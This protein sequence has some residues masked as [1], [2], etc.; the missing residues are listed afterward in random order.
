MG[1]RRSYCKG[2]QRVRRATSCELAA[3]LEDCTSA[4][5]VVFE[6]VC[7][8]RSGLACAVDV[9]A[10]C[11]QHSTRARA[12][13]PIACA[14]CSHNERITA[15]FGAE[16]FRFDLAAMVQDEAEQQAAAVQRCAWSPY[17]A[18][19]CALVVASEA[20]T[21]TLNDAAVCA[22]ATCWPASWRI[23]SDGPVVR[24]CSERLWLVDRC[25]C[26]WLPWRCS[27]AHQPPR[28]SM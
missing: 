11:A 4:R 24:A 18:C 26:C 5:M 23:R 19:L 9:P 6:P 15:N 13:K 17:R 27:K 8:P 10:C 22:S 2:T 12:L 7:T 3:L 1:I 21:G 14:R 16:P 25:I 28:V 20:C